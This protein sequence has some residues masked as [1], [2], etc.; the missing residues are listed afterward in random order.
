MPVVTV[1]RQFGK[2]AALILDMPPALS[3]VPFG[4]CKVLLEH[5]PVH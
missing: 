4:Q 3:G 5:L 1:S 2:D